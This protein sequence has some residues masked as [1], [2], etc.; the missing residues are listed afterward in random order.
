MV[1]T[2]RCDAE[3][4]AT[5]PAILGIGYLRLRVSGVVVHV[6]RAHPLDAGVVGGATGRRELAVVG[7][8]VCHI[9]F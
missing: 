8:A 3:P 2:R 4:E 5:V 6:D 9:A 1:V 7:V